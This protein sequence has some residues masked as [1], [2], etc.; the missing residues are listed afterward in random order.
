MD[1]QGPTPADYENLRSLNAAFLQLV[2]G[3][4]SR[5]LDGLAPDLLRRLQRLN[6]TEIGW[7]AATPFLLFSFRERDDRYWQKLLS[8]DE[9][10]DL[11]TVPMRLTDDAGRLICAGLGFVWQ[12]AN[13]NPFAARLLCGASTHWCERITERTF[14]HILAIAGHRADILVLR[15]QQDTALWRKLLL[16]GVSEEAKARHAAHISALQHVLT[17]RPI[18][19]GWQAAACKSRNPALEVADDP[20]KRRQ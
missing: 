17:A 10:R 20:W 15:A 1:F 8:E 11:F 18:L 7:L 5:F 3:K 2:Q 19:T 6:R 12:L 4:G 16:A 9:C 14:L 13:H